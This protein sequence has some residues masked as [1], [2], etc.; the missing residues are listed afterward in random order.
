M[1]RLIAVAEAKAHHTAL[2]LKEELAE[3]DRLRA[4]RDWCDMTPEERR[5]QLRVVRGGD[6]ATC[7]GRTAVSLDAQKAS[8]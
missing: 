5:Q 2:R 3:L 7:S 1:E 8:D 6:S 4:E